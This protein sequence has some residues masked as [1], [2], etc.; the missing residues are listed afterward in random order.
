MAVNPLHGQKTV[1]CK[2]FVP[3]SPACTQDVAVANPDAYV[4]AVG[5]GSF[6]SCQIVCD[7]K[8][9]GYYGVAPGAKVA[10]AKVF[11]GEG[12]D[13]RDIATAI[14]WGVLYHFP[15]ISMSLGGPADPVEAAAVAFAIRHHVLVVA[16]SGNSS[17]PVPGYPAGY[18]GVISVGASTRW[19]T[20]AYFSN[21]NPTLV[22]P[23][24]FIFGIAPMHPTIINCG[25]FCLWEGT[26]MATPEVA[27][28]LAD[29]LSVGL[30]PWQAE[31]ALI[32]GARHWPGMDKSRYGHGIISITNSLAYAHAKHWY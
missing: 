7:G 14:R 24:D 2:Y 17:Q 31:H 26:S 5:H 19:D 28:A 8:E 13:S 32:A 1:P 12:A 23:G 10:I 20:V 4:D 11:I 29:L 21:G 18:P 15:I 9:Y 30:T 16:A 22:A 27:G 3:F 25:G 6:V